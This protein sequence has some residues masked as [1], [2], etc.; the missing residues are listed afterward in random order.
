MG[1]STTSARIGSASSS[2]ATG[3]CSRT[4]ETSNVLPVV[5]EAPRK[6]TASAS[7]SA[8]RDARAFVQHRGREVREPELAGR[9]GARARFHDDADVGD[10]DFVHLHDPDGQAV[11]E[12]ALLNRRQLERRRRA[13]DGRLRSIGR[14]L[15]RSH[16]G[17]ERDRAKQ[18]DRG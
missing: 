10:R 11:G 2:F 18:A 12:R 13:D 17:G 5:S 9:I 1:R 16:S 3:V 6:S 4:D 7:A 15:R 8:S 14:L